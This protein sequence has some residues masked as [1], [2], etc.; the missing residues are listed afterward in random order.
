VVPP[1]ELF[2][3]AARC[4]M[5][6]GG[7]APTFV[8]DPRGS[9]ANHSFPWHS[10]GLA[11]EGAAESSRPDFSPARIPDNQSEPIRILTIRQQEGHDTF[12]ELPKDGGASTISS[13]PVFAAIPLEDA[14]SNDNRRDELKRVAERIE[15]LET[16]E[17]GWR[18]EGSV[19]AKKSTARDARFLID[20]IFS[21][22]LDRPLPKIG[23]D[24]DGAFIFSWNSG[25]VVASLSIHD[26]GTYSYFIRN[27]DRFERSDGEKT[28]DPLDVRFARMLSA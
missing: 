1:P 15:Y 24:S 21:L 6:G 22:A 14:V 19:K 10:L 23:L 13:M 5:T 8:P 26:D 17:D 20:R 9:I 25:G 16:L 27:N 7:S 18:G 11:E 4:L 3:V 2:R 28:S 12:F